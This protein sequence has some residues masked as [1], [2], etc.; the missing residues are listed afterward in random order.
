M[1][2][3]PVSPALAL[4]VGGNYMLQWPGRYLL[5]NGKVRELQHG[6]D[7][8]EG[9]VVYAEGDEEEREAEGGKE[10]GSSTPSVDGGEDGK[11]P[12]VVVPTTPL[13]LARKTSLLSLALKPA[14]KHSPSP[15]R[16]VHP[17]PLCHSAHSAHN[18]EG[19]LIFHPPLELE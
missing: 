8:G 9:G 12:S 6:P 5:E 2:S 11:A 10:E 7:E 1:T 15:G 13:P 3:L 18:S 19:T 17:L 16:S 4:Y 14:I